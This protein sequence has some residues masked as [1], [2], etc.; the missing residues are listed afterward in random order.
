[1]IVHFLAG[2]GRQTEET[3]KCDKIQEG[4]SGITLLDSTGDQIGYI[5]FDNLLYAEKENN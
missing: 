5:P 4:D 1:M 2:A 3:Q